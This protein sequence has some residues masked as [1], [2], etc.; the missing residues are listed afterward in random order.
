MM[1]TFDLAGPPPGAPQKVLSTNDVFPLV[2]DE[3]RRIARRQRRAMNDSPTIDT[4]ALVHEAYLKLLKSPHVSQLE[5][6]HFFAIAA[7]AMRQILVDLARRRRFRREVGQVTVTTGLGNVAGDDEQ[8]VDLVALDRALEQLTQFD[9]RAG[10]AVEWRVFG[11][12][13]INEIAEIQGVT[14]RT[15]NRDWRRACAYLLNE[16][17]IVPPAR[18]IK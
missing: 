13:A 18:W 8:P 4:T 2:Y 9:A 7:R 16:L 6:S 15:V 11:G 3:L 1:R 17:N 5:R 10:Q 14:V 12:L